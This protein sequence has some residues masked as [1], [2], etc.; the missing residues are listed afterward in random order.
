MNT[1]SQGKMIDD[2]YIFDQH[3]WRMLR[4]ALCFFDMYK[5]ETFNDEQELAWRTL[6]TECNYQLNKMSNESATTQ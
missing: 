2:H 3:D 4:E 1:Q 6:Y 5:D